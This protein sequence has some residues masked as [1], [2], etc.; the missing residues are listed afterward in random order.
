MDVDTNGLPGSWLPVID[1]ARCEAKR[2]CVRVC[3]VDVFDVRR[4]DETD[5]AVLGALG[6]LRSR[7]HRRMTAYA[8]RAEDCTGCGACVT[9]CPEVAVTLVPRTR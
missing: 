4:I 5:F 7:A 2:D 8:V 3:P 6:K 1:H 9:A